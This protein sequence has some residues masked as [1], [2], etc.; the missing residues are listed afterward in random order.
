MCLQ[1]VAIGKAT[2]S[3]MQAIVVTNVAK[4]VVPQD[5]NR[6]SLI[7]GAPDVGFITYSTDPAV[8]SGGGLNLST[9]GDTI[10][11]LRDY[12]GSIVGQ[13]WF[14]IS[15]VPVSNAAYLYSHFDG[16]PS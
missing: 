11:L 12:H 7:L 13:V 8:A 3:Q 16:L 14:A 4:E 15:S 2:S 9:N 5:P 10:E 6:R 1:D